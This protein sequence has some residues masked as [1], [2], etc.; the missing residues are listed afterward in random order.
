MAL[1]ACGLDVGR[2]ASDSLA[3]AEANLRQSGW[4]SELMTELRAYH[5]RATK[6]RGAA[7]G[8]RKAIAGYNRLR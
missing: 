2:S 4:D 1:D 8:T 6:P 7:A 3:V 5:E